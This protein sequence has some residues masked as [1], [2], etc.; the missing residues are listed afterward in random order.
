MNEQVRHNEP[1][2]R[3]IQNLIVNIPGRRALS[4]EL[5]DGCVHAAWI[6]S[7]KDLFDCV[8]VIIIALQPSQLVVIFLFLV[9]LF[10]FFGSV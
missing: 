6:H 8:T 4:Q 5:V 3:V 9:L 7:D 2:S 10:L 1:A